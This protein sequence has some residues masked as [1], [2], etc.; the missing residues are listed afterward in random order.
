MNQDPETYAI[1]GAALE[2]HRHL[3]HGFLEAVY[4]EA[5]AV[6]MAAREIPFKREVDLSITY[7]GRVLKCGYRADFLCFE[8]VVVELKA[9]S[10]LTGADEAQLIN[11]LKATGL[12]RGLLLNFGAPSLESVRRVFNLRQSAKSADNHIEAIN[13]TGA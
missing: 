7:K 10:A 6:E 13:L 4:Q 12:N 8:S 2:V 1:I 9:I 5:L 3:G 11:E